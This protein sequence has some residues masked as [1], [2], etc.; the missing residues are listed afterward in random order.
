ME[1]VWSETA[2]RDR[3][4]IHAFIAQTRSPTD[5]YEWLSRIN[6]T[7]S[8]IA[9]YPEW[10]RV[11]DERGNRDRV[12]AGPKPRYIVRYRY[13]PRN[14]RIRIVGIFHGTQRRSP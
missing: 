12:A 6:R 13:Q 4:K 7:I 11:I 5:A 10:S 1:V 14:Q 2:R 9:A 3:D 8:D